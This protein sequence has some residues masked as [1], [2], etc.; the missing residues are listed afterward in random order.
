M[1]SNSE[2]KVKKVSKELSLPDIVPIQKRN[3]NTELGPVTIKFIKPIKD[4]ESTLKRKIENAAHLKELLK[5]YDGSKHNKIIIVCEDV[6]T[7]ISAVGHI[8]TCMTKIVDKSNIYDL[9]IDFE[10]DED[11]FCF[12]EEIVDDF[13]EEHVKDDPNDCFVIINE[14]EVDPDCNNVGDIATQG[15]IQPKT[16]SINY[17]DFK[18]IIFVSDGFFIL[19]EKSINFLLGFE[20]NV[21]VIM[22]KAKKN[23][24]AIQQLTFESDFEVV[25]IQ[26]PTVEHLAVNLSI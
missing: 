6:N 17:S 15:L 11:E 26:K 3:I 19:T 21:A 16:P 4:D 20:G 1:N 12:S 22:P 9:N 10:N 2:R 24:V 7:G 13:D 25:S 5:L 18:N 23:D 14:S 8:G